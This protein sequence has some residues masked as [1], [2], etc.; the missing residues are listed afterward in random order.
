MIMPQNHNIQVIEDLKEA[1]AVKVPPDLVDI[2]SQA[3]AT[4]KKATLRIATQRRV[5]QR[6]AILVFHIQVPALSLAFLI[7]VPA[8]NQVADTR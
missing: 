4:Q 8:P 6:K 1:E 3:R 2:L 5:T 7:L